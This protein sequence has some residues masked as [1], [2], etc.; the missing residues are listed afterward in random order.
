MPGRELD[1][2]VFPRIIISPPLLFRLTELPMPPIS[3][4]ITPAWSLDLEFQAYPSG[5]P[6]ELVSAPPARTILPPFDEMDTPGAM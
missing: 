4:S 3:P 1:P 5:M 6:S 2:E